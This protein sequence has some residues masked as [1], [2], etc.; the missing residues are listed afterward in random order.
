M[1]FWAID[2]FYDCAIMCIRIIVSLCILFNI[3]YGGN[4]MLKCLK[5]Q[6]VWCAVSGAAAIIIGK[7]VIT[8]QKTRQLT[9]S[10]LAKC[11]KLKNDAT[12][13]FQNMKDEASDICY[14]AKEEA[15][16]NES[17]EEVEEA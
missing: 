9:V 15:G 1:T 16:L 12:A 8:A 6:R 2:F 11:M 17:A 4:I 7:K 5:D 14:D 10:G 3:I 13:A